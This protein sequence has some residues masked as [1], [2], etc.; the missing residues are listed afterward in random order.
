MKNKV[1]SEEEKLM[2]TKESL[3]NT[4][5]ARKKTENDYLDTVEN[6]LNYWKSKLNTVDNPKRRDDI[7]NMIST[8]E[9]TINKI[10]EDITRINELI[11]QTENNLNKISKVFSSL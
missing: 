7:L 8:E 3:I 9:S 5:Y 11:D 4:L 2:Q 1:N 6:L 10:K